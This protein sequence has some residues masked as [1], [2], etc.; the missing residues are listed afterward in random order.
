MARNADGIPS[1]SRSTSL[2]CAET[3]WARPTNCTW[4][5]SSQSRQRATV[6]KRSSEFLQSDTG[7]APLAPRM[8]KSCRRG[9]F[10]DCQCSQRPHPSMAEPWLQHTSGS[11]GCFARRTQ[12]RTTEDEHGDLSGSRTPR[13]RA[14]TNDSKL[15]PILAVEKRDLPHV[16]VRQTAFKLGVLTREI[17][18]PGNSPVPLFD[19]T[20]PRPVPASG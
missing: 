8:E 1:G 16:Q 12:D 6:A 4:G 2:S 18:S 11:A 3:R 10:V 7:P 15:S 20:H 13:V 9:T 17:E 19:Q 14:G 5:V